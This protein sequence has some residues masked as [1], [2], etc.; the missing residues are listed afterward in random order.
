MNEYNI[1]LTEQDRNNLMLFLM[2]VNLS[3]KEALQFMKI[4]DK[5]EKAEVVTDG[6]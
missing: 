6:K 1:R 4:A 5:I 3:G 2:R